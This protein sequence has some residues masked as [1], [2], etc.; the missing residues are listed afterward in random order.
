MFFRLPL[1][2][3]LPL[4]RNL[5]LLSRLPL[6][7]LHFALRLRGPALLHFVLRLSGPA[8]LHSAL[9]L[10]DRSPHI[11]IGCKGPADSHTGW[12]AM[13]D[14]LKLGPVGAG[15]VL[16]LELRPHGRSVLLM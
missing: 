8:L 11:A 4:L 10:S 3:C 1:R 5:P 7:L 2:S 6:A 16:I 12:A 14:A 15:S 9:R 13:I